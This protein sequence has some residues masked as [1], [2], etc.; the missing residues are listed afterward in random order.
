MDAS[1]SKNDKRRPRLEDFDP[2]VM[3]YEGEYED[4]ESP[5]S[6]KYEYVNCYIPC[7]QFHH[8]GMVVVVYKITK[9]DPRL[10]PYEQG[11]VISRIAGICSSEQYLLMITNTKKFWDKYVEPRIQELEETKENFIKMQ[12]EKENESSI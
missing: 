7:E 2:A 1:N 10:S 11:G 6:Y 9:T 5:C 4:R 3:M 8:S 12:E